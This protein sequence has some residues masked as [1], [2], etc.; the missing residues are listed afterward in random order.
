[1][2]TIS[3]IS[4]PGPCPQEELSSKEDLALYDSNAIVKQI[5]FYFGD[6]NLPKDK[7]L[8]SKVSESS[9]GWVPIS[10]IAGFS[11]INYLLK[12]IEDLKQKEFAISNSLLSSSLIEIDEQA[13]SLRR[14][15]PLPSSSRDDLKATLYVKGFPRSENTCLES[16]TSFF[17]TFSDSQ[18]AI[19]MRRLQDEK[20]TFKGSLYVE[21]PTES[22]VDKILSMS[23]TPSF[24]DSEGNG[25]SLIFM[26]KI[27]HIM[28]KTY[29]TSPSTIGPKELSNNG[30]ILKVSLLPDG[31]DYKLIKEE[32]SKIA[33]MHRVFIDSENKVA[34]AF[35][36]E[37]VSS[38]ES[39]PSKDSSVTLAASV[40][41]NCPNIILQDMPCDLSLPTEEE[42]KKAL[43]L[44]SCSFTRHQNTN[45]KRK[46]FPNNSTWKR[47][48]R[49]KLTN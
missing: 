25:H 21:F 49:P 17:Q 41:A 42:I 24:I 35:I 10:V 44:L 8:L 14:K 3:D 22:E 4:T 37:D 23:P 34:Y 5:E 48:S 13:T 31:I 2:T 16:L 11:R 33:P 39:E 38:E 12:S 6:L 40:I 1:M 46:N 47:G 32:L 20:K 15:V 36:K 30:S 43:F 9:E 19:R 45:P 29:K 7:F 18:F 26:K 28:K 27:D